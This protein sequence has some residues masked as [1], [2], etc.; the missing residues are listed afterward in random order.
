MAAIKR[1]ELRPPIR[2]HHTTPRVHTAPPHPRLR[3][4]PGPLQI[5]SEK[6]AG[7][8]VTRLEHGAEER[9]SR[10]QRRY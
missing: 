4:D 9:S 3:A 10:P 5:S 8:E 6:F 7:A 1:A 2:V